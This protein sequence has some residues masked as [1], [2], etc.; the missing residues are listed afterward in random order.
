[1]KVKC[2]SGGK[3]RKKIFKIMPEKSEG[4]RER[5]N[6]KEKKEVI[7]KKKKSRSRSNGIKRRKENEV[8]DKI[9]R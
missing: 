7:I 4:K 5:R 6:E 3:I 2:W 1:M 8:L 9:L